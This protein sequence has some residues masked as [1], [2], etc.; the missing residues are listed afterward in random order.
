[1]NFKNN[2][3]DSLWR[4]C[5]I[6][7][8]LDREASNENNALKRKTSKKHDSV[9]RKGSDTCTYSGGAGGGGSRGPYDM[10]Q[11]RLMTILEVTRKMPVCCYGYKY[12]DGF[13]L[14]VLS[15]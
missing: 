14:I 15:M 8:G 5:L 11:Q 4:A 6:F 10:L 13:M 1:M 3:G 9:T 12:F 7:I 2:G